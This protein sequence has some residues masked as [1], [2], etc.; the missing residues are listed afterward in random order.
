MAHASFLSNFVSDIRLSVED[1]DV[2][3]R[4]TDSAIIRLA[5]PAMKR[6]YQDL[7]RLSSKPLYLY[8]DISFPGGDLA[9][10]LPPCVGSVVNV[11]EWN[12]DNGRFDTVLGTTS[13]MGPYR[14]GL[15]VS[16]RRLVHD[17]GLAETT[18][19]RIEFKPKG[20]FLAHEASRKFVA[21]SLE[22]DEFALVEPASES[23]DLDYGLVDDRPNAYV[24]SFLRVWSSSDT[25]AVVQERVVLGYV[26]DKDAADNT[27]RLLTVDSDFDPV[28]T[29]DN[30]H[31]YNYEIVPTFADAA[32][33][34][35]MFGAAMTLCNMSG[36]RSRAQDL[37]LEYR[38][39]LRTAK[40][41]ETMGDLRRQH[42]QKDTYRHVRRSG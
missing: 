40:L 11:G 13:L 39:A 10:A 41:E 34:A 5:G 42:W 19:F 7:V 29:Q 24:G 35:I 25:P 38:M 37:A 3:A 30:A 4:F 1:P 27:V 20:E 21:A 26:I 31:V 17:K 15:R 18:T 2:G 28:L 6:V 23:T 33:E 14:P 8:L 9:V 22:T 36:M 32:Q 16:G 12:S